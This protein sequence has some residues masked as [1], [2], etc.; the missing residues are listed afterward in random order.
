MRI[1]PKKLPPASPELIFEG[2][3][4]T[5]TTDMNYLTNRNLPVY[6]ADYQI[7]EEGS[8]NLMVCG[9]DAAGNEGCTSLGFAAALLFVGN[10]AFLE[11]ESLGL[12]LSIPADLI[13]NNGIMISTGTKDIN[14]G[15]NDMGIPFEIEPLSLLEFK[16]NNSV[17]SGY[18]N[19]SIDLDKYRGKGM[20]DGVISLLHFKDGYYYLIPAQCDHVSNTLYSKIKPNGIFILCKSEDGFSLFEEDHSAPIRYTLWQNAPNPFN[21][22]TV[23]RFSISQPEHV[24]IGIYNILGQNIKTISDKFYDTGIYEINWDGT[25]QA[26][27]ICSSGVYFYKINAGQFSESKRMMMLK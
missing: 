8:Y 27:N 12:N 11:D 3:S 21:A 13:K 10:S 9:T 16:S 26:G 6:V 17:V 23:I 14:D 7:G 5:D 20:D 15:F 4:T 24:R 2:P 25:D 1:H 19:L 18:A 22:S